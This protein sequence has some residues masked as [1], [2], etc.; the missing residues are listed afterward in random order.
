MLIFERKLGKFLV[1][2]AENFDGSGFFT[3]IE[4]ANDLFDQSDVLD[5]ASPC[6]SIDNND[7]TAA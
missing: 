2:S 1:E 7:R 5:V 6:L 4:E 3:F